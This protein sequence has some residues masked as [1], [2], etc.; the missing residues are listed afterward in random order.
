MNPDLVSIIMVTR[1]R[2]VSLGNCLAR[3]RATVPGSIRIIV[4]D[5]AS[6]EPAR[7]RNIVESHSKTT[8]LR[9]DSVVGPTGGRNA[10][11]RAA[12]TPFC[13]CLDDDCYLDTAPE[14]SK[15][16]RDEPA[17]RDIAVVGFRYF[18]QNE[19]AYAPKSDLPGPAKGFLGGACLMR[20]E[21]VLRA[22][23]FLDWLV[24][25]HEDSELAMRLRRLG[26]RIWYDP[27][28]IIQHA[29]SN[30][31]RDTKWG[32]YYY[33][34]NTLLLSWLYDPPVLAFF[35]GLLKGLRHASTTDHPSQASGALWGALKCWRQCLK[36]RT[37]LFGP[38]HRCSI[39]R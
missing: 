25:A 19:Q 4:F 33:V 31:G 23:G 17:D 11:L 1:N 10:C 18:N 15:W 9:S 32:S 20:R 8:Y 28:V 16:L 14:L 21:S 5:D 7:I 29:R 12:C 26:F 34:R 24:F 38:S 36:A 3:T 22:G 35:L 27:T 6:S 37:E 2:P 30:E 13:L 39:N